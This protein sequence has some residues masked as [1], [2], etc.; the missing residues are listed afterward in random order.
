MSAGG[1]AGVAR[2]LMYPRR[3]Y[4]CLDGL[5]ELCSLAEVPLS[6]KGGISDC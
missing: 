3:P 6:L 5:G 1:F 2:K 4:Y